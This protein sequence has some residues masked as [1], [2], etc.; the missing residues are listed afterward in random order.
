MNRCLFVGLWGHTPLSVEEGPDDGGDV[1]PLD[2][3]VLLSGAHEHDGLAGGVDHGDGGAHL[4]VDRVELGE[5]DAV[6]LPGLGHVRRNKVGQRQVEAAE[7]VHRLVAHK[8]LPHEQDQVRVVGV[9]QLKK[10]R[11]RAR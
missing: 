3:A 7:L 11:R 2:V 10:R 1:H 9:H 8:G 4:V 6:D 5:D